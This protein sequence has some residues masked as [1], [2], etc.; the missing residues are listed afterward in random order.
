MH[1]KNRLNCLAWLLPCAGSRSKSMDSSALSSR[2]RDSIGPSHSKQSTRPSHGSSRPPRSS[3]GTPVSLWT[4]SGKLQRQGSCHSCAS[5]RLS[6]TNQ[7]SRAR[8]HLDLRNHLQSATT[9]RQCTTLLAAPFAVR[10]ETAPTASA[11]NEQHALECLSLGEVSSSDTCSLL[12]AGHSLAGDKL[13]WDEKS[14]SDQET[15]TVGYASLMLK[16]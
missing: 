11:L 5:P 6:S 14:V 16:N 15:S 13:G 9:H 2:R 7:H 1:G 8:E 4:Q 12:N 10:P 3:A